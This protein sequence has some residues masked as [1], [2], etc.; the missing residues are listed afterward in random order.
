ML[1]IFHV[2][3]II[4]T[5]EG[6]IALS[7]FSNFRVRP[8]VNIL[9]SRFAAVVL[10]YFR[11]KYSFVI[12]GLFLYS[13]D[14][15]P[16]VRATKPGRLSVANCNIACQGVVRMGLLKQ[17]QTSSA[18]KDQLCLICRDERWH[19]IRLISVVKTREL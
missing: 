12:V 4:G 14:I 2:E 17:P 10:E 3:Y 13:L 7:L 9:L 1:L 19:L 8:H 15:S 16:R 18:F 6:T 11:T 5:I